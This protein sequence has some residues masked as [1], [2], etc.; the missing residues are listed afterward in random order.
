MDLLIFKKMVKIENNFK[1]SLTFLS[2]I[3]GRSFD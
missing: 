3:N 2:L 1:Y